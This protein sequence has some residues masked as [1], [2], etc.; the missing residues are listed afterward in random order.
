MKKLLIL[1]FFA[2]LMQS[3]AQAWTAYIYDDNQFTLVADS[4]WSD[5][6][7]S[8][9]GDTQFKPGSIGYIPAKMGYLDAEWYMYLNDNTDAIVFKAFTTTPICILLNTKEK[10]PSIS[11]DEYKK[12][13]TKFKY[14]DQFRI[15]D[16]IEDVIRQQFVEEALHTKAVDNQIDDS[17]NGF[18][19]YF[20]D[21]Y[22]DKAV[23]KDGYGEYAT[24]FKN[25]PVFQRLLANAREKHSEEKDVIDEVNFQCES[26]A[27][28]EV[29]ALKLAAESPFNYNYAGIWFY[30]HGAKDS[31]KLSDFN[32]CVPDATIVGQDGDEVTM[33][34]TF[35]YFTFKDG[36]LVKTFT[37]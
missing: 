29:K 20:K 26:L 8:P 28:L 3:K 27:R 10:K 21:G 16:A 5:P 6:D 35:L 17:V 7:L 12:L 18:I 23:T 4:L 19:Y 11:I 34:W 33:K 13:I 31:A 2:L 24:Q 36:K 15:F 25:K 14:E 1:F 37:L 22:L 32:L 30:L 9:A